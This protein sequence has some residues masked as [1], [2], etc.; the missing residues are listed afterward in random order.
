MP[1][2]V[3]DLD[4]YMELYDT[5]GLFEIADQDGFSAYFP[6]VYRDY[7]AI[8]DASGTISFAWQREQERL[9]LRSDIIKAKVDA[10]RASV[11]F[12]L[13]QDLPSKGNPPE[14]NLLIG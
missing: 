1:P 14:V 3:K 6:T 10:G 7:L 13:D 9:T 11:L 4:G 8:E 2:G 5:H 12:S